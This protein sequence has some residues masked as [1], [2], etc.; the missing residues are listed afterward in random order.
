MELPTQQ[1][2]IHQAQQKVI[3]I[4]FGHNFIIRDQ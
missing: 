2:K 4:T 3:T 1:K